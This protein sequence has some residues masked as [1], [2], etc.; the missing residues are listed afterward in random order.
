MQCSYSTCKLM[1]LVQARNC[2]F[3]QPQHGQVGVNC[4]QMTLRAKGTSIH[5]IAGTLGVARREK[6]L[7]HHKDKSCGM[8]DKVFTALQREATASRPVAYDDALKSSV[9]SGRDSN[10]G[11]QEKCL[12]HHKHKPLLSLAV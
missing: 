7:V 3:K 8:Q 11:K 12:L 4:K 10:H 2:A 5:L 1:R 9:G 6:H